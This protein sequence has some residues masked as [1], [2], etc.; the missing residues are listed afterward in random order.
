M[1]D[2]LFWFL[3]RHFERNDSYKTVIQPS[4]FVS[5]TVLSY[6][7][8]SLVG[9]RGLTGWHALAFTEYSRSNRWYFAFCIIIILMAVYLVYHKR[10]SPK[11]LARYQHLHWN[12]PIIIAKCWSFVL[13][14]HIVLLIILKFKPGLLLWLR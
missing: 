14:P 6:L 9:L 11:I 4:F 13:A 5:L 7:Y 3:Y 12:T 8:L 1:L 10:Q 2:F